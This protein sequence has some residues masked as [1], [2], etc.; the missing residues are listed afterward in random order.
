LIGLPNSRK[1][2]RAQKEGREEN[3]FPQTLRLRTRREEVGLKRNWERSTRG[4]K[5][6]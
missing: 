1:G 6:D 5:R 4:S 2:K 3:M